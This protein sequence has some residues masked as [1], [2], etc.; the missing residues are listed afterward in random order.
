M[1]SSGPERGTLAA[2]IISRAASSDYDQWW[3]AVEHS[4]YCTNP[5]HLRGTGASGQPVTVL[6]RCGN[7]RAAVCPSCSDLYAADTWQLVHAGTSGGRYGLPATLAQHP[8]VFLTLTAPSFGTVHTR[9][10]LARRRCQHASAS[11]THRCRHGRA[12]GCQTIHRA[13][14]SLLGQAICTGCYDYTGQIKF[15][16]ELPSLWHRY[17]IRLRREIRRELRAHG[18]QPDLLRLSYVKVAEMQRRGVPHLHVLLRLDPRDPTSDELVAAPLA[19]TAGQL[20]NIARRVARATKLSVPMPAGETMSLRFG[21]QL[22]AQPLDAEAVGLGAPTGRRV[23]A[24]VA[25]YVTKSVTD[26]GLGPRRITEKA[27]DTLDVTDHVRALLGT[28]VALADDPGPAEMV[29]WLHT[30]AYRG[31]IATKT[32]HYST[33]MTALRAQRH[34]WRSSNSVEP[35][36]ESEQWRFIGYGRSSDGERQLARTAALRAREARRA[37]SEAA[38]AAMGTPHGA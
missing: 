36:G 21:D 32:R 26:L 38:N 9:H 2:Q 27:I 28:I 6:S 33:T 7:R 18:E 3:A 20:A 29:R 12:T 17:A 25:K 30:L 31:H 35:S 24:Y 10:A 1:G 23:A 11:P 16:W 22:D 34:A 8:M 37:A 4:G 13:D 15:A 19:M 14:D 5:I